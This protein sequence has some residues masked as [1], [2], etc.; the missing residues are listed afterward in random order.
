MTPVTIPS[1]FGPLQRQCLKRF[2][3]LAH[4]A[5]PYLTPVLGRFRSDADLIDELRTIGQT[6]L[7]VLDRALAAEQDRVAAEREYFRDFDPTADFNDARRRELEA[8]E[9]FRRSPEG[10][11]ERQIELLE[12]IL[13]AVSRPR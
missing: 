12:Q 11:Q 4:W 13:T 1:H 6:E 8:L 9:Q 2:D 5:N 3:D 10:R 7:E